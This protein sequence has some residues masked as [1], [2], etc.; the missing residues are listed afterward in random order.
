MDRKPYVIVFLGLIAHETDEMDNYTHMHARTS[1][2][3]PLPLPQT[4]TSV[5]IAPFIYHWDLSS[6]CIL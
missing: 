1:L 6:N 4:L 2:P 5:L 3:S